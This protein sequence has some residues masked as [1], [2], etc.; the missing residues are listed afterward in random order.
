[1]SENANVRMS[2]L[3]A[4]ALLAT[5]ATLAHA[6]PYPHKPIRLLVPFA[7]GGST[8]VT[9]R[10]I[11]APVS[12][13]LGQ[14]IVI[15]NRPGS[16][17][18]IATQEAARA[19]KDGYTLLLSSGAQMGISPALHAKP[20]YDPLRDFIHVV[21][22]T[23][24]PLVL[25]AHPA[26]PV[27]NPKELVAYS[28]ANRAKINTAST[29]N[30]TYTHLTL[31]L[32][33]SLTGADLTHVPYKGAA[34]ALNDLLGRQVQTMFTVTA[35]AQPYTS[36]GRLKALGITSAKRSPAMPD[37]PTFA[38]SGVTGI[39]VSSWVGISVP[40]GTPAQ[41]IERLARE[42]TKALQLPEVKERLTT[43][44][45]EIAGDTGETFTRMVRA[46][47]SRWAK[48][49]KAAGLKPE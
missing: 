9:A 47:V 24:T 11:G 13:A 1:M 40:A 14:N 38:E 23:D 33:K 19:P 29:G 8:D 28:L 39:T 4:L 30:G 45:A 49:V 5:A 43:L 12:Q 27:A 46:D 31:E 34:P 22:L 21:H 3:C 17:G 37:V 18:L 35:S 2:K 16:G 26:L 10:L 48:V 44:G 6:Q 41:A 15:D 36:S 25:I 42:F 32:F 7:P 20:G